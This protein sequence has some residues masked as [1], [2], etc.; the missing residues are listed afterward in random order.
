[1]ATLSYLLILTAA[2]LTNGLVFP[3]PSPTSPFEANGFRW[4]GWTPKTTPDPLAKRF[5]AIQERQFSSSQPGVFS[6][7]HQ[8]INPHTC[9][10]IEGNPKYPLTCDN[11]SK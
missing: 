10:Y 6:A 11:G 5:G 8:E 4:Q 2:A 9:G 1:M 3:S 7:A